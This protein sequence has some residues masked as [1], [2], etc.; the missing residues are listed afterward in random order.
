[1]RCER[2]TSLCRFLLSLPSNTLHTSANQ[3]L[4]RTLD[5]SA[6]RRLVLPQAFLVADAALILAHDVARGL[7]VFPRVV[8]RRLAA[9]LPFLASEVLLAEGVKA[10]GD[11]QALHEALRGHALLAARRVKEDGLDN[12][13]F[14]RVAADPVFASVKHLLPALEDPA[15]FVGRAPQQVDEFLA[16]EL[17]PAL[18]AQRSLGPQ[19]QDEDAG[20]GP[21]VRV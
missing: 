12:D 17:E 1:M 21:G 2:L 20:E 8:E 5:D 4:E 9:E 14:A 11:R 15:R 18:Q 3:W 19:D 6:N 7:V 10:G 16:E 13:L